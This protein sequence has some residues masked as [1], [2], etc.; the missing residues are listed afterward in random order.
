[1]KRILPTLAILIIVLIVALANKAALAGDF[2]LATPTTI[3]CGAKVGIAAHST[4]QDAPEIRLRNPVATIKALCKFDDTLEIGI[5]HDS[6]INQLE[7][8]IGYNRI[9]FEAYVEFF[10]NGQ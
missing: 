4:R 5:A 2:N 7:R 8:G 10:N 1:M 3:S 9:Y 6:G